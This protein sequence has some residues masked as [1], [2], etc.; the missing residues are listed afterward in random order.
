V[1]GLE[2]QRVPVG[3]TFLFGGLPTTFASGWVYLNL[4]TSTGAPVDPFAQAW[5]ST[6]MSADDQYSVG[7]DAVQFDSACDPN[8]VVLGLPPG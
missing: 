2:T 8:T 7:L 1:C 3:P 6:I 5:V 4:N